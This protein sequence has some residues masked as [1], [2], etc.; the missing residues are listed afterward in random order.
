[1]NEECLKEIATLLNQWWTEEDI[2]EE[3]LRARV[4]LIYKKGDTGLFENYR[5]ISLLNSTYNIYTAIIQKRLSKTLDKHLQKT[6]FWVQKRQKHS[7]CNTINKKSS[8]TRAPNK[9]QTPFGTSRL[10]KSLRQSKPR[11]IIRSSRKNECKPKI[12]QHH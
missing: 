2:P 9:Q 11:K 8:R 3:T 5:P 7:R 1:M 4:V 10:G 12:H 6:Q